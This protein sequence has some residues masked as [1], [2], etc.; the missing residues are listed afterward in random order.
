LATYID[1]GTGIPTF[2]EFVSNAT[3]S[4][5]AYGK[6]GSVRED[7]YVGPNYTSIASAKYQ[8]DLNLSNVII[9]DTVTTIG[10]SAFEGCYNLNYINLENVKTVN[11]TAF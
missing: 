10:D 6:N 11:R 2:E 4:L 7:D 8:N 3:F 9:P 5:I 1:G